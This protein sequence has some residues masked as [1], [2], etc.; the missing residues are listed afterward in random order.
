MISIRTSGTRQD[1][2]KLY[3]VFLHFFHFLLVVFSLQLFTHISY[4]I[5]VG[6]WSQQQQKNKSMWIT[7]FFSRHFLCAQW[8]A[9]QGEYEHGNGEVATLCAAREWGMWDNE[10]NG[11]VKR[12]RTSSTQSSFHMLCIVLLFLITHT[13]GSARSRR[14]WERRRAVR[15]I[16]FL[17]AS[18]LSVVVFKMC[19][20]ESL[21]RK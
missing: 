4:T 2:T 18:L 15:P 5:L 3:H 17:S 21:F 19:D 8:N 9:L 14:E 1:S 6:M 20:T 16:L 11:W 7:I 10:R 13:L 12:P